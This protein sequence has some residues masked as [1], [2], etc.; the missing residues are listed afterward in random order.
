LDPLITGGIKEFEGCIENREACLD[1]SERKRLLT[2]LA[3]K[4]SFSISK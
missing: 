2:N 3:E 1:F 4:M